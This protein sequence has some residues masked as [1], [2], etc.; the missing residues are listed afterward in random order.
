[1]LLGSVS[2]GV[3]KRKH[4]PTRHFGWKRQFMSAHLTALNISRTLCLLSRAG[5]GGWGGSCRARRS[6]TS[7]LR[8]SSELA[9]PPRVTHLK[10][11]AEVVEAARRRSQGITRGWASGCR[12]RGRW[13]AARSRL[14]RPMP[15]LKSTLLPTSGQMA[16]PRLWPF[17]PTARPSPMRR[18]TLAE[19]RGKSARICS[20]GT[21]ARGRSCSGRARAIRGTTRCR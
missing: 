18:G 16:S 21:G 17:H 4:H 14:L 13:A 20:S 2:V 5:V 10:G 8:P 15:V 7:G 9:M 11:Q 12:A 3:G 19:R 1:M 6:V